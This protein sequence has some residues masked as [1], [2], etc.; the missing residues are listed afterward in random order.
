MRGAKGAVG[1]SMGIQIHCQS[2]SQHCMISQY[3]QS[4]YTRIDVNYKV[5][6]R[7]VCKLDWFDN[8]R[9]LFFSIYC[10]IN[11]KCYY[12]LNVVCLRSPFT[13]CLHT[14]RGNTISLSPR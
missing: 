2:L 9:L 11:K 7:V 10:E 13:R 12:S 14:I 1:M 3:F 8:N 5:M 6:N 4:I